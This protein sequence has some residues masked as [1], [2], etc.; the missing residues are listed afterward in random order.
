MF[1]GNSIVSFMTGILVGG[2][3]GIYLYATKEKRVRK[4]IVKKTQALANQLQPAGE[5]PSTGDGQVR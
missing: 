5:G 4:G 1:Q 2:A 3:V